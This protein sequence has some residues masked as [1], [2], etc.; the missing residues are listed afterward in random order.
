MTRNFFQLAILASFTSACAQDLDVHIRGGDR[1]PD[2]GYLTLSSGVIVNRF[3]IVMRN[4]RLQSQPTDGGVDTTPGGV[5]VGPGPFIVDLVG[6]QLDGG[7]F[8]PLINDFAVG[9]KGFYELDIDLLPVSEGDVTLKPG[10]SP[11]LGK[12]FVIEGTNQQGTPFKFESTLAK[13]LLRQSV[14]RMGMNHNNIDVNIAPNLWFF[15]PDGGVIDPVTANAAQRA[16]VEENV[17][18][19]IDAYQD[20]DMNGIP[21]PLG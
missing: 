16:Q 19:S 3:Q 10:L 14:F 20:D 11:M 8:T 12:T 4:L 5:Y 17:A 15:S 9:A 13:V 7:E 18:T 21:D 2:P 6:D 1:P